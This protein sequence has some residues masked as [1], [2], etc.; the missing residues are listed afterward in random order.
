MACGCPVVTYRNSSLPEVAGDAA[1]LVDDGDADAM[2]RAA[3]EIALDAG[4]A[5]R[6]R[7]AGLSRARGFSWRAAA[8]STIAVYERVLR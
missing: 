8:K 2:G 5:A 4:L 1:V 7:A 3:A 6:L